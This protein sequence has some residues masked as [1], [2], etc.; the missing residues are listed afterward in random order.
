MNF[1]VAATRRIKPRSSSTFV[2]FVLRASCV[3]TSFR[4]RFAFR[5]SRIL[6]VL[7]PVTV[8]LFI[9]SS[10]SSVSRGVPPPR[11]SS[12]NPLRPLCPIPSLV[13][14]FIP[15]PRA[16]EYHGLQHSTRNHLGYDD[17]PP[18]IIAALWVLVL[19]SWSTIDPSRFARRY[20]SHCRFTVHSVLLALLYK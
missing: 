8:F 14:L 15:Q 3:A 10:C 17:I 1:S 7:F 6:T 18:Q 4:G 9:V 13:S 16:P 11:S 20:H 5:V 12:G 2:P 19:T